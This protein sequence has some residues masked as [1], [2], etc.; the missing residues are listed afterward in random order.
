MKRSLLPSSGFCQS[1]AS[2]AVTCIYKVDTVSALG[3]NEMS[4]TFTSF[5]LQI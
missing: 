3:V 2:P 5:S 4:F 1:V